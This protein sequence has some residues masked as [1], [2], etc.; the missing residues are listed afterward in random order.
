MKKDRW[1]WLGSLV[2]SKITRQCVVRF[3]TT[4]LVTKMQQSLWAFYASFF[5]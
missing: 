5:S 2:W 1:K 4:K 3:G